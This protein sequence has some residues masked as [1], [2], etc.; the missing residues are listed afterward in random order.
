MRAGQSAAAF[1]DAQS[2]RSWLRRSMQLGN[3][4]NLREAARS[5]LASLEK[6]A[7]RRP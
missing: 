5:A 1:G 3:D 6:P 7:D 2:A 4:P